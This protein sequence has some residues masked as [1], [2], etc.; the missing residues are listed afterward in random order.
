MQSPFLIL[1]VDDDPLLLDVLHRAS[2]V[3]FPEA[4]F[5]QVLSNPEAISYIQELDQYGPKL[6]LLDV[7]LGSNQSGLD[8]AAFLRVHPQGRFLPLVMLSIDQLPATVGSAY[9]AGV[10][11]FTVKP[12]SFG[13]WKIYFA[14]LRLYWFRTVT[15]PPVRFHKLAHWK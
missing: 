11:S 3:S 15:I 9:L 10:S 7:D 5:I 6:I 14:T 1:L 4:S 12:T 8:F 13:D 2:R